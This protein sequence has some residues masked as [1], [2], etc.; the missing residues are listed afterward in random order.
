[1]SKKNTC[2][3]SWMNVGNI[4]CFS[5]DKYECRFL[6]QTADGSPVLIL[7]RRNY[8]RMGWMVQRGTSCIYF[9]SYAE[10]MKFCKKRYYDLS[11]NRLG[12][13]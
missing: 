8:D 6:F 13:A 2:N 3:A 4:G 9:G 12:K 1:M 10:A 5:N 7:K 11:G